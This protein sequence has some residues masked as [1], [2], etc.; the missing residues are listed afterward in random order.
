MSHRIIISSA[1][2]GGGDFAEATPAGK[3]S[4]NVTYLPP[5]ELTEAQVG[6]EVA[7]ILKLCRKMKDGAE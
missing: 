6:Q 1:E 4:Y 7:R 2:D 5:H 3:V